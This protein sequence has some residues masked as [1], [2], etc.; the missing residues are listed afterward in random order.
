M[1]FRLFVLETGKY[2]L[3]CLSRKEVACCFFY[4]CLLQFNKT[5]LTFTVSKVAISDNS[6][7]LL[8]IQNINIQIN[9]NL[10]ITENIFAF[11]TSAYQVLHQLC[12]VDII[13]IE[14][15]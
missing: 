2:V 15:T 9:L 12:V 13:L 3:Y 11:Y 14:V 1:D 8:H 7:N 4:A 10:N 5:L 6:K